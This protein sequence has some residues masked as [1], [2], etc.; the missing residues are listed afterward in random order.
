MFWKAILAAITCFLLYAFVIVGPND[1]SLAMNRIVMGVLVGLFWGVIIY[2][3][4]WLFNRLFGFDR[5]K[6][7]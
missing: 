3:V 6:H 2:S 1:W 5:R 4:R 7:H